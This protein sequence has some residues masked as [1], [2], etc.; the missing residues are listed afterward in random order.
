MSAK[1]LILLD[2]HPRPIDL[3][4]SEEDRRRLDSLA[5]VLW[6]EGQ[7]APDEYIEEHL[8]KAFAVVGQTA[9]PKERLDRAPALRAIL[10][11]EGNFQTT[12]DYSECHR[13]RIAVLSC[14]TAFAPAVA[15]MAL[16]LALAAAR[17][18]VP[19]DAAF[20]RGEETYSGASNRDAFLLRGRTL[21][22]LGRG[23]VGRCLLP[24][25][26]PFSGEILVHDPWIHDHVL[27]DMSVSP[28][29]L[30]ELLRRS[31]V[32]FVL[33]P[34]TTDSRGPLGA[35]QFAMMAAGSVVVLV[36][37]AGVV[38]FDALLDAAESGHLRAAIDVFPAE[39]VP[40]DAR[41]R[42]IPNVILSGHRSGGLPETYRQVGR[43]VV[44]DIELILRGLPPQRM[45]R[46]ALETVARYRSKAIGA[47]SKA[48]K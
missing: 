38:D 48:P 11:V 32:L 24:L 10:N 37:R 5:E 6:Y 12:I 3:I 19:N 25:L 23:G 31:T 33:A 17:G 16:A 1:P 40:A 43:M 42:R 29:G 34:P 14:G 26:R 28:V 36:S 41:A 7:P 35:E 2:P 4:F 46:A 20:R 21:G 39:P 9:L 45:Q 8:P 18:I 27:E 22:L 44:D 30:D 13:R 15:E 47:V